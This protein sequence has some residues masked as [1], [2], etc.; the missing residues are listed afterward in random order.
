MSN[1]QPTSHKHAPCFVYASMKISYCR[2]HFQLRLCSF[3]FSSLSWY[4][5]S[6]RSISSRLSSGGHAAAVICHEI[7]PTLLHRQI[8]SAYVPFQLRITI[9]W[10]R[11]EQSDCYARAACEDA[12]KV[13]TRHQVRGHISSPMIYTP[14]SA[15]LVRW[16]AAIDLSCG[17]PK[18]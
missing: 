17:I 18:C 4:S 1:E 3:A 12:V 5:S 8:F 13:C 9:H 14:M 15:V 10:H 7:P 2:S 16:L 6:L 11:G